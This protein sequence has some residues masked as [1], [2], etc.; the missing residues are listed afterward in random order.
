MQLAV[1]CVIVF[2]Q[3]CFVTATPHGYGVKSGALA[4][5]DASAAA[6]AFGGLDPVPHGIPIG[7][8]FSGSYSKSASSSSSSS[9]ASSSSSSFSYSGSV[10]PGVSGGC[11][12]G[13]CQN[14]ETHD[15]NAYTHGQ[16]GATGTVNGNQ[17]INYNQGFPVSAGAAGQAGATAGSEL[18]FG[19]HRN[20][21]C[22]GNNCFPKECKGSDCNNVPTSGNNCESGRCEQP[23]FVHH[24]SSS[25]NNRDNNNGCTSGQC[26]TS[27]ENGSKPSNFNVKKGYSSDNCRS[28]HC[29]PSTV[30]HDNSPHSD[31]TSKS[32]TPNLNSPVKGTSTPDN[33]DINVNFAKN[34]NSNYNYNN[35]NQEN[36]IGNNGKTTHCAF[37]NCALNPPLSTSGDTPSYSPHKTDISNCNSPNCKNDVYNHAAAAG[38][39]SAPGYNK[40]ETHLTAPKQEPTCVSP[41]CKPTDSVPGYHPPGTVIPVSVSQPYIPYDNKKQ[42]SCTGGHCGNSQPN[43][44]I[45]PSHPITPI[46]NPPISDFGS[47]GHKCSSPNCASTPQH[48]L[49]QSSHNYNGGQTSTSHA[50]SSYKPTT[51]SQTPFAP[52]INTPAIVPDKNS[53]YQPN[54]PHYS[55]PVHEHTNQDKPNAFGAPKQ[56]EPLPSFVP[57]SPPRSQP[58]NGNSCPGELTIKPNFGG[59]TVPTQTNYDHFGLP[60]KPSISSYPS[61]ASIAPVHQPSNTNKPAHESHDK[62]YT[63]GFGGP[64]GLLKPNDYSLPHSVPLDKPV[65]GQQPSMVCS[66][67]NCDSASSHGH[68][69]GN[70]NAGAEVGSFGSPPG[71]LKPNDYNLPNSVPLNKPIAGQQP[72]V[73]C[74]AGNCNSS[75]SEGQ[76][77]NH[78]NSN[79]GSVVGSF[80]GPPGLLKPNDYNFPNSVTL[81]KPIAGQQPSVTCSAGNCNSSPGQGQIYNNRNS[82]AGS[83][84]GSFGGP[85]GLLKPNDFN[86]PNTGPQNK[87]IAGYQ[88]SVPCSTGTG[89]CH[90]APSQGQIYNHGNSNTGSVVGSFES[91]PGSLKPND[92]NSPSSVSLNKP[93]AAQ[94]PPVPCL[95]GN[96]Q[97]ANSHGQTYNNGNS[98]AITTVGS[99]GGPPGLL[100]PNDFNLPN[101]VPHNKPAAEQQPS[102]PCS[103][104]NCHSA[105]FQGQ[106]YNNGNSNAAS[107]VASFGGPPGLLKPNDYTLGNAEFLNKPVAG[108]PSVSCSS[109]NCN[110]LAAQGLVNNGNSNKISAT[111]GTTACATGKCGFPN[112]SGAHILNGAHASAGAVASANAVVYT[113]GFG[114]PPGFLKPYDDGNVKAALASLGGKRTHI[115]VAP[116]GISENGPHSTLKTGA[117]SIAQAFAAA[118]A[119]AGALSSHPSHYN[120]NDDGEHKTGRGCSGDCSASGDGSHSGGPNSYLDGGFA[121]LSA[122]KAGAVTGANAGSIGFGGS[123]A[124]SSA[125]AHASAGAAVKGY[126]RR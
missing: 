32:T 11:S 61:V 68:I 5:A 104:G 95:T 23:Q 119:N 82:N 1:L 42:F 89:N 39:V 3:S 91:L 79:A 73:T 60:P 9:S 62:P 36:A 52:E 124:S 10:F 99:F 8:G 125:S 29:A 71:L 90:S 51:S 111:H 78:G 103:T 63:G 96:C 80:E 92:H 15:K 113:G 20:P 76:I 31:E 16:N 17:N 27:V 6:G 30:G 59:N 24:L 34:S 7:A 109:G 97:G 46:A 33:E 74:S 70:S 58:C 26:D 12:T 18:N 121:G 116:S 81:N 101:T 28:G 107:T 53:G 106:I 44:Y 86:L 115:N 72:S 48:V 75:P 47:S 102:V 38:G 110:N 65:V 87:P 122:A 69:N 22:T 117:G 25:S 66:A 41:Y 37:G 13:A 21:L 55:S 114:G 43:S 118:G 98:N 49:N 64:P 14:S 45:T 84:V 105:H 108:H 123:F 50:L 57:L 35:N 100:K 112:G 54:Q 2:V 67:G 77:Y 83:V 40:P 4:K 85:P 94:Q 93:T 19:N 88:P 120:H 56:D 126:G